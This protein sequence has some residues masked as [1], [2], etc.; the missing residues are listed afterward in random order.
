MTARLLEK[1]FELNNMT[2]VI[3]N[4]KLLLRIIWRYGRAMVSAS[5]LIFSTFFGTFLSATH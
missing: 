2:A 5:S 3:G 4:T 1:Q